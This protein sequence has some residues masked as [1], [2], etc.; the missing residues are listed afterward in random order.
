MTIIKR[1]DLGRPLTWDELDDNFQQVDDLTAAASA[2][3]SSASASATAAAGSATNSLNSAN[4]AAASA[5]D[6]SNSSEVAIN[7]LMNSTFEPSSFDFATGGTLDATDRNK[8]VYNPADNN[9]YSWS[10][11]LPHVVA[12]GTDPTTDSNWK[13]RTDQLLRQEL[14]GTD[15]ETLGDAMIGVRQP[16]TGSVSRTMHDKVK[17]SI[18]IADFGGAP[19]TSASSALSSFLTSHIA[20]AVSAAFGL[21]GEYLI[22][23]ASQITLTE[24]QSMDVDFSSAV[25]IQNANVSPL[26]ISNGFTGP[27]TVNSITNGQYNL[28]DGGTNSAVSILDIPD[29]GL[30]VGDSAKIISD[31]ICAFNENANQRRGEWFIV[32]AVSGNTVVTSGRLS[33]TYSSN[34]KVVRPSNASV[35][36]RGLRFKSTIADGTTAAMFTV[37]GFFRPKIEVSFEDLNATGLSVTGCFQA[38]VMVSGAYLKNRPDLSAYGYLVNDSSSQE[39]QVVGLRCYYARHAYTTTTGSTAANDDNWYNRGRTIDSQV[40]GGVA[41]GCANA[42]DTHGPALR[43]TFIGCKA[44]NDYRGYSTGGSG[45]QIRGQKCRI[46][47]CE[48]KGSKIGASVIGTYATEEQFADIDLV[49]SGEEG[50]TAVLCSNASSSFAQNVNVKMKAESPASVIVDARNSNVTLTDPDIRANFTGDSG[51]VAQLQ[52]GAKLYVKGGHVDLSRSTATSHIIVKHMDAS[53]E[54]EVDGLKI[55]GV[56]RLAYLA[57]PDAFQAKSRWNNL[58]LDT[59][60]S[61]VAFLT[62]VSLTNASVTYRTSASQK[63]LKYR[64]LTLATGAQAVDLQYSGHDAVNLRVSAAA[65]G[66]VIN[67]LTR[68]AFAGQEISIGVASN[69]ANSIVVQ[70]TSA[71]LIAMPASVTVAAGKALRMYWDGSNWQSAQS[72]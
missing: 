54:A 24:G 47:A 32:A 25:F 53:T 57:Q 30:A 67:S 61:G 71:G 59:A 29:H 8:A 49:Y 35:N 15:D 58:L 40:R 23:S 12:A 6:A 18:S 5:L 1:A 43:V 21:R 45:F 26:V 10:G 69:S 19:G 55:S 22:D 20:D 38:E 66:T 37:R 72:A 4:S 60:L 36:I 65:A 44:V 27:W 42:F 33:E 64:A 41:H 2:A 46:V 11:T 14:A 28:G 68:G 3:V 63:P 50:T 70:N 48:S 34:V 9:W 13:P 7:A 16:Y 62:S 31:D 17:E 52:D 56:N 39:T 51:I